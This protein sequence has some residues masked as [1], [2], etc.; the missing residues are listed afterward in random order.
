MDVTTERK[1]DPG[2]V[3]TSAGRRLPTLPPAF[4]YPQYRLYWLGML[5]RVGGFQV[6]QFG[7]FWLVFQLTGSPLALGYIGLAN[8]IPAITLNLVGGVVADRVD[9]RKLIVITQTTAASMVLLLATL[10]LLEVVQMWHLLTI[11]VVSGAINAFSQPASQALY[12]RLIDRKAMMSAVALNSSIWQGTRVTSPAIA[13]VLIVWLGTPATFFLAAG[14]MLAFAIVVSGLKVPR[15]ERAR[16]TRP[17]ADLLEGLRFIRGNSIFS[18]LISMT[19]F[20]SFFGMAYVALMPIFAVKIL[21]VGANGQGWLMTSSG[22]GSLMVTV[23]LGSRGNFRR[24]GLVL[25]GGAVMTGLSIATFALT[26]ELIGSY[27]LALGVMFIFGIFTSM[28]MISIMSSLQMMVPNHMRGRVMGFYGMTWNIM[29][30]GGMYAGALATLI[31]APL[32]I[33]IGGLLVSAFA[34]GP[35]MLNGQVRNLSTLL[36]RE[37]EKARVPTPSRA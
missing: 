27:A 9:Q 18:F 35:A 19:F 28:Y 11:A 20:N 21:E 3:D 32:A 16:D 17:L 36:A 33:A 7:Q 37:E 4:Q 26:S 29:P 10:T 13:G 15:A 23:Y 14:G 25:I 30:L 2:A 22:I 6:L 8:A 24:K 31:G 12:P 1:K 5:A 34:L